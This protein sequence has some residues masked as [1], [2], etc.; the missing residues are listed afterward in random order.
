[1]RRIQTRLVLLL[2]GVVL[3]AQAP[4][5]KFSY[6]V[7]QNKQIKIM[8]DTTTLDPSVTQVAVRI[9]V[10]TKESAR[11]MLAEHDP[12]DIDASA[13][14][15]AT[16]PPIPEGRAA[17]LIDLTPDRPTYQRFLNMF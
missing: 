9:R 7:L 14:G 10:M 15:S 12:L 16:F 13:K 4:V 8:W 6:V 17:Y 5:A 2:L 11:E 3:H 1:M